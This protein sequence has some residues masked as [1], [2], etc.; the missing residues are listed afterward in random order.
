MALAEARS[1]V[2][3]VAV[4][5]WG[6]TEPHN[7]HLPFGTDTI[8]AEAVAEAAARRAWEAGAPV[9]VL[10]SIPLGANAQQLDTP[11]TLNL[12]PSTQ[13]A[14]LRDLVGSLEA[15]AIRKLLIVNGH[16]GNDFRQM[17]REQPAGPSVLLCTSNWY[18]VVDPE[19][20][21]D[22]PGDHAGEL[23]TSVMLHCAPELV[24]PLDRAGPGTARVFRLAGL[25]DGVA[26][27]P[28]NWASVTEDTGVGNPRA[29]SD[30]KGAAYFDEVTRV[31]GDFLVELA[32]ADP[33]DLY[34][35]PG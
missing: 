29:A 7:L 20:Y 26:W 13:A 2:Y 28:R 4:L 24:L 12:N 5:P 6:A 8:Q 23:E 15:H 16:G 14:V 35:D 18:G 27:T 25:R 21:F 31:L 1:V 19:P 11:L 34:I 33:D 17:I 30:E 22:E 3:D 9:V 10:P 32:A